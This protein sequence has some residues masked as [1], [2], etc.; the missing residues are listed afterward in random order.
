MIQPSQPILS[1]SVPI[2]TCRMMLPDD[3]NPMGNVHGGTILKLIEQAGHVVASRH[4][5]VATSSERSSSLTP[6]LAR[7]EHM[8]F[9]NAMFVG[10]VAQVQAKVTYTSA[11]SIEVTVDVW[12]ENTLTSTRRHTNSARLWYVAI[13][14][15]VGPYEGNFQ[16]APVPQLTGLSETE[17]E[18]G[19]N[20][21]ETQKRSRARA[22]SYELT[23]YNTTDIDVPH[24]V[25]H[26]RA[27]LSSIVLPSDCATTGHMVGGALMK[28]MDSAAGISSVRHCRTLAVTACLDAINFYSPIFNGDLVF[29]TS[30]IVFTSTKSLVVE[31]RVEAEGL[32]SGSRRVTNDAFF[33]FVSLGKMG[34]AVAVPPLILRN[35][36]ERAKFEQM[37][38]MYENRKKERQ[39]Q[40][41]KDN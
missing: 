31:V 21:Y 5:N 18:A 36:K 2:E 28:M 13:P 24:T 17:T 4:C 15:K 34:K 39:K 37:R 23:K 1:S 29:V 30:E 3:T 9:H 11:H 6:V 35:D 41:N 38:I 32:S 25:P 10:E 26:S 14:S 40:T 20:R 33:T 7:V 8:D 16:P 19:R 12:A 22:V 27:T